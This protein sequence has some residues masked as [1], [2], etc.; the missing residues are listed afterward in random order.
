VVRQAH[1]PGECKPCGKEWYMKRSY[2]RETAVLLSL[3]LL[4]G[5]VTGCGITASAAEET[6]ATE[7]E[8]HSVK[9]T[10]SKPVVRN[11]AIRSDFSATVEAADKVVVV[12]KVGGEVT[13]KN[14]EV[15][16]HVNEGDL[17]FKMDDES[18]RLQLDNAKATLDSAS[19]GYKAQQA[20]NASTKAQANENI[21]KISYN[22][23]QLDLAVD[24]AYAGK[25]S[26]GNTF[27]NAAASARYYEYH[28]EET[29]EDLH[30]TKKKKKK[31][32]ERRDELKDLVEEY[33][34]K[35]RSDGTDKA[36]EWLWNK[37]YDSVT[38]LNSAYSSASSAYESAKNAIDGYEDAI[39]SYEMMSKIT[40][41]NNADSA[42]MNYYTAEENV[43]LAEQNR[44]IYN[45]YTKATTIFGVN[46]S[47]VGADA[48]LVN[49]EAS[50]RQAKVGVQNAE[51]NLDNYTVTAPVSGT[52]TDIGVSLHNMASQGTEAYTIETDAKSKVVFFVAEETKQS[53]AEGNDAVITKNG[54]EYSAKIT[55]VGNTL[56]PETGLFKI[57][58]QMTDYKTEFLNGSTVSVKTITR[59]LKD[60]VTVPIDAV[61]Y[62]D[63]QAYVFVSDNGKAVRR[64]IETG[65][66]DD[67]GIAVIEG[68]NKNEDVIVSWSSQLKDGAEITVTAVEST[69]EENSAHPATEGRITDP[70]EITAGEAST[71]FDPE[72]YEA[73]LEA[74]ED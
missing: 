69:T 33:K 45:T 12:P 54:E 61:Y 53:I 13:E 43:A 65:I 10:T 30:D 9:V 18:A 57:E 59:E 44:D 71:E 32:K 60:T 68:L 23:A 66:S 17:L 41:E 11:V 51:L 62:D 38:E 8:D 72:A 64:D 22:E 1:H 52:I 20:T 67:E 55:N 47:V 35:E 49:S 48:S 70:A 39:D 3:A 58:A 50:L 21:A 26:A 56:D 25:R 29:E 4:S 7:E 15:G 28:N 14:F 46:A 27:E 73:A 36:N 40:Y 2:L 34:K 16:D 5:S 37:G 19:A 24:N 6:A 63:E 31:L 42:E 74:E